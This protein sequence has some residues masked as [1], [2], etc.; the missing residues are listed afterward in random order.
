MTTPPV[1]PDPQ[2]RHLGFSPPGRWRTI[3]GGE[4]SSCRRWAIVTRLPGATARGS[5]DL[6]T[7]LD[8]HGAEQRCRCPGIP[9]GTVMGL[10]SQAVAVTAID[11]T[12]AATKAEVDLRHGQCVDED[13]RCRQG[14][15][16]PEP[17]ALGPEEG[18]VEAFDI[19]SHQ[20]P[21]R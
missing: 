19:V 13:H 4:G 5:D 12:G 2:S 15:L 14:R 10:P 18:E 11:Q 20:H 3:L 9:Q 17:A 1:V 6:V 8:T 21:A 16:T 7:E